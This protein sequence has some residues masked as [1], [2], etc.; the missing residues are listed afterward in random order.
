[1]MSLCCSAHS[2]VLVQ[3]P[4][5]ETIPGMPAHTVRLGHVLDAAHNWDDYLKA[6]ERLADTFVMIE[7]HNEAALPPEFE[8]WQEHAKRVLELSAPCQEFLAGQKAQILGMMNSN[9]RSRNRIH[10]CIRGKCPWGCDGD[11]RKFKSG[12]RATVILA[13]SSRLEV[14]LLYRWK[15]CPSASAWTYRGRKMYFL[16]R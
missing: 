13:L 3:K 4:V 6:L 15:G 11:E 8:T 16:F 5:L 2:A 10:Y 12:M 7:V 9:W 14:P 1:M